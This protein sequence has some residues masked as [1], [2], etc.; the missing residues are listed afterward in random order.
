MRSLAEK[1]A[2]GES[3]KRNGC[4]TTLNNVALLLDP[5]NGV[6]PNKSSYKKM[7]KVHQSTALPCPSPLMISGAKYSCVPTKDIDRASVGS[8]T[9][10]GKGVTWFPVSVLALWFFLDL[11]K[12][13]GPKKHVAA[14]AIQEGWT[15]ARSDV[16]DFKLDFLI[17]D[18]LNAHWRERSK[19]E[20]MMCPSSLTR[21][22]SGLRSR[23][24]MPSMCRYSSAR[25]TSAT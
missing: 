1:L 14:G 4:P 11:E 2:V 12:K 20:S 9:S 19:S 5:L 6:L 25:R 23:Y 17:N 24:M 21:T 18:G 10:S 16:S 15:Q 22:F 13:R 3:G 7:P 8:A